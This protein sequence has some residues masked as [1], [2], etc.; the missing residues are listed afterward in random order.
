MMKAAI[1]IN[2]FFKMQTHHIMRKMRIVWKLT[3]FFFVK[4]QNNFK[5]DIQ[6]SLLKSNEMCTKRK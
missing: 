1:T 6:L 5:R 3:G 4:P 2:S